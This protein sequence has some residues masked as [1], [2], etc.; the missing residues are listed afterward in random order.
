M[1]KS[2]TKVREFY[3]AGGELNNFL[4]DIGDRLISINPLIIENSIV[5]IVTY[6]SVN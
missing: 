3:S 6:K 4:Q 1:K 2:H 5:Y